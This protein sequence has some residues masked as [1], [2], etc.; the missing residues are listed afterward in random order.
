VEVASA[1]GPVEVASAVVRAAVLEH[2]PGAHRD[3]VAAAFPVVGRRNDEH[4]DAAGT[5]RSSSRRR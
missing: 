5:S 2:L 3:V 4:V 1:A